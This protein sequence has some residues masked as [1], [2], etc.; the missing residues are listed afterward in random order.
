[1]RWDD[2]SAKNQNYDLS[3][4][5]WNGSAWQIIASSTNPQNG[6]AGQTPTEYVGVM[7]SGSAAPYGFVIKRV[8]STRN[9][10]FEIFAPKVARLDEIVTARSLANLADAPAAMTVAALDVNAPYPQESYSSEGPT[11]GPGGTAS[12]GRDQARHR[13]VRQRFDGQLS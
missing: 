9:V 4:V 12:R 6:G 3:I 10:N 5:K 13:R 7:S 11:N 8:S 1:M 2:W